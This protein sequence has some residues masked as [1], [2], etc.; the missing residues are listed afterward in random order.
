MLKMVSSTLISLKEIDSLSCTNYCVVSQFSLV[1]AS[2]ELKFSW[3]VV[4]V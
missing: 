2:Q 4:D 1:I 3:G